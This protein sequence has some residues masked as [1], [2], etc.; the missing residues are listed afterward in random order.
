VHLI[1]TKIKLK[2][3]VITADVWDSS[4]QMVVKIRGIMKQMEKIQISNTWKQNLNEIIGPKT[5]E[6]RGKWRKLHT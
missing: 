1:K 6:T 2:H 4:V 3:I 5:D